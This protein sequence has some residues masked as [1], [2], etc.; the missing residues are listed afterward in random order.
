MFYEKRTTLGPTKGARNLSAIGRGDADLADRLSG[1]GRRVGNSIWS[2]SDVVEKGLVLQELL[3]ADE[4][5]PIDDVEI[6][7]AKVSSKELE[8]A[9]QLIDSITSKAFDPTQYQD[10]VK[11]RIEAQIRRRSKARRSRFQRPCTVRRQDHRHHGRVACE[12]EA[13]GQRRAGSAARRPAAKRS[14]VKTAAKK[15]AK[16]AASRTTRKAA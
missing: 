16:K 5:R 6:P 3:Y 14:A 1:A 8:L 11:E 13:Q 7:D 4:V 2:I 15:P 12:L 10:D 9:Q